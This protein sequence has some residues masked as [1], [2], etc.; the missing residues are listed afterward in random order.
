MDIVLEKVQMDDIVQSEFD[1]YISYPSKID[2]VLQIYLFG[3][4]AWGNPTKGSDLDFIAVVR[5]GINPLEVMQGVSLN[6]TD[7]QVPLDVLVDTDSVFREHSEPD[8]ATLQREIKY[9]GTLVYGKPW[10]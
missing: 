5:D 1:R 10:H 6:L 7:R 4:F 8:R 9:K 2:G 3:S